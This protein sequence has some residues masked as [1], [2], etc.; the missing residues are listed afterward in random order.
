MP[1]YPDIFYHPFVETAQSVDTVQTVDTLACDSLVPSFITNGFQGTLLPLDRMDF[2][3]LKGWNL[4]LLGL[5]LLLIVLNKQLYPRQ[6]RQILSVPSGVAHTNQ[7]LREW[8]PIRSFL[9]TSFT[10]GYILLIALFAQKSLVVMSHDVEGYNSGAVFWL[11]LGLVTFWLLLRYLTLYFINWM[12]NAGET[13]DRQITVQ[14]SISIIVL[15]VMIPIVLLL[16]Y[17]PT[18][19]FVWIGVGV[20]GLAAVARLVL[21]VIETRVETKIP[22]FYIFSYFCALELAPIATLVSAGWRYFSQGTVL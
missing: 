13:V 20:L 14:F 9:C 1:Q 2:E 3:I 22:V 18:K 4:A 8:S 5:L 17:N 12:F 19:Y 16:M 7:L 11:V 6:F 10:L 21:G 15:M